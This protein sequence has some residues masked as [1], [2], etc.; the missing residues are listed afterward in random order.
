VIGDEGRRAL[1]AIELAEVQM[2]SKLITDKEIQ[3]IVHALGRPT[4]TISRIVQEAGVAPARLASQLKR[5]KPIMDKVQESLIESD[6]DN[7]LEKISFVREQSPPPR[8]KHTHAEQVQLEEEHL[9]YQRGERKT[10]PKLSLVKGKHRSGIL[11]DKKGVKRSIKKRYN[12]KNKNTNK[13]GFRK[14]NK[15]S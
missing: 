6:I 14:M 13:I 11:P 3:H 4:S 15:L 1:S 9:K 5:F 7:V 2:Q 12:S 10:A 8:Y